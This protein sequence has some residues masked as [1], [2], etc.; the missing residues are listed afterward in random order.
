VCTNPGSNFSSVSVNDSYFALVILTTGLF[1][2]LLVLLLEHLA[3]RRLKAAAKEAAAA[4]EAAALAAA[5]IKGR[6]LSSKRI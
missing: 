6:L 3:F 5:R 4:A 2:S 1:G